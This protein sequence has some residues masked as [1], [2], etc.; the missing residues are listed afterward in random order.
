MIKNILSNKYSLLFFI[1]LAFLYNIIVHRNSFIVIIMFVILLYMFNLYDIQSKIENDD[2]KNQNEKINNYYSDVVKRNYDYN[3]TDELNEEIN[4]DLQRFIDNINIYPVIQKNVKD[5]K[6]NFLNNDELCKELIYNLRFVGKYDNGDYMK[7]ILLI[8]NFL[9][10]YYNVIIDRYDKDYVDVV[11]D[12]RKEILNILYNF[13]VD[14]PILTKKKINLH[15]KI[16]NE[17]YKFQS[18]SYKKIKN[19]S[20]KFPELYL[21]NPHPIHDED[22]YDNYQIIV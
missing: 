14:S 13:K 17:I 11:L 8:E 1:L 9:K 7:L 2:F 12:L 5:G 19:L 4:E 22:L 10:T 6:L 16:D 20:K 15:K 18:Y 21:K 3:E